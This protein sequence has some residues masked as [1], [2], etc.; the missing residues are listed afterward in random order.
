MAEK[1]MIWFPSLELLLF[2]SKGDFVPRPI[3]FSQ[4]F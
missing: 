4:P 3:N 1:K 2:T